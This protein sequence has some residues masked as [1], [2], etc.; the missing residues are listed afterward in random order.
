MG[1]VQLQLLYQTALLATELLQ[2]VADAFRLDIPI[3]IKSQFAD[4]L[5]FRVEHQKV[6]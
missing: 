2:N 5:T 1:A 6:L 3:H 4:V